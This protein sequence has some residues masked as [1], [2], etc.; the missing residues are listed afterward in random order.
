MESCDGKSKIFR[1]HRQPK[2]A[3]TSCC[4]FSSLAIVYSP[5]LLVY[6]EF[7]NIIREKNENENYFDFFLVY[8]PSPSSFS[9]Q[10]FSVF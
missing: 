6:H 8:P 1:D 9:V 10:P 2:R 4:F 5:R 3:V 7:A